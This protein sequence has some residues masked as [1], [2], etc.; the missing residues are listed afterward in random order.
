V[1]LSSDAL[2]AVSSSIADAR[3]RATSE[4]HAALEK[5]SAAWDSF[6]ATPSVAHA[7]EAAT[8]AVSAAKERALQASRY[9][10]SS[11][12]YKAYLEPSVNKLAQQPRVAAALERLRPLVAAF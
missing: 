3:L 7:L 12:H 8:P 9:I 1:S 2:A 6:L 10:A 11:P 5:V 4:A